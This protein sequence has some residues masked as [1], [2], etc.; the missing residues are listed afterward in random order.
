MRGGGRWEKALRGKAAPGLGD[1]LGQGAGQQGWPF[2]RQELSTFLAR[3][4]PTCYSA[5]ALSP[6]SCASETLYMEVSAPCIS[7]GLALLPLPAGLTPAG[8]SAISS[9]EPSPSGPAVS[10]RVRF[11]VAPEGVPRV[12]SQV[13]PCHSGVPTSPGCVCFCGPSAGGRGRAELGTPGFWRTQS[14]GDP[15]KRNWG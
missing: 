11:V 2:R 15:R 10:Q 1:A 3:R 6:R 4:P 12:P 9:L 8:A 14:T 13:V 7:P 5:D